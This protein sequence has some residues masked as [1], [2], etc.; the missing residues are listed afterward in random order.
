MG[1]ANMSLWRKSSLQLEASGGLLKG[2]SWGSPGHSCAL[3][4]PHRLQGEKC[5]KEMRLEEVRPVRRQRGSF[6]QKV[7]VPEKVRGGWV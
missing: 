3:E 6:R 7:L 2:W 4:R 1:N 5:C